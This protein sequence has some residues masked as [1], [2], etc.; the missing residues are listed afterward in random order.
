MPS[1]NVSALN[2]AQKLNLNDHNRKSTLPQTCTEH[3][4]SQRKSHVY[5]RTCD[6]KSN[7]LPLCQVVP[8]RFKF[9]L[10]CK[11]FLETDNRRVP[12]CRTMMVVKQEEGGGRGRGGE[13]K[14]R[15]GRDRRCDCCETLKLH[16][17]GCLRVPS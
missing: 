14:K 8:P 9:I 6:N 17:F 15:P 3:E 12:F 11:T 13:H 7:G 2:N 16:K 5:T 1:G 4:L 10:R